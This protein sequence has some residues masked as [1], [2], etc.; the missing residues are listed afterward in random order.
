MKKKKTKRK[1]RQSKQTLSFEKFPFSYLI[2]K[3]GELKNLRRKYQSYSDEDRHMAADYE[4]HAS[5][6]DVLLSEAMGESYHK[7]HSFLGELYALA[8]DPKYAPA[9]LTV[10]SYEYIYGR[11][12][13]TMTCFLSLTDLPHDT[14]DIEIIIDKACDFLLD[15][16][17]YQRAEI[18]Y[19]T[20]SSKH[21]TCAVYRNG[22]AY[23][24]QKAGRLEEAIAE[25]RKCVELEPENHVY[26]ADLGWS[27]VEAG[28]YE[29]AEDILQRALAISPDYNLAKGNLEELHRRIR[30]KADD[31]ERESKGH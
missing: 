9:I 21:P 13:E 7:K 14:E 30:M 2:Q 12:E 26:L 11:P 4:Y 20:A 25:E 15:T 1:S 6:A 8:I 29:E 31:G 18:L 3:S 5:G 17:D 19:S 28:D 16:Q 27:L 23:C 24:F 10:G 22:L